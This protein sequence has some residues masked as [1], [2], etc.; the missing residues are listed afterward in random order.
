VIVATTPSTQGT[1]T[2]KVQA[3]QIG[4]GGRRSLVG[5]A[6][7]TLTMTDASNERVIVT[8]EYDTGSF[9]T[10]AG[11]FRIAQGF[12][13]FPLATTPVNYYL[14]T[15]K[16]IDSIVTNTY[17]VDAA[18]IGAPI[19]DNQ[20]IDA[21]VPSIPWTHVDGVN[22][23]VGF[24]RRQNNLYLRYETEGFYGDPTRSL[25]NMRATGERN[26][27]QFEIVR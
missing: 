25:A 21:D 6:T 17:R 24:F 16:Q 20:P 23:R 3:F 5:T 2:V 12:Y 19:P 1:L 8:E 13:S 11:N 27:V 4:E 15:I 10:P 18:D 22:R 26:E 14:I 9:P 7:S